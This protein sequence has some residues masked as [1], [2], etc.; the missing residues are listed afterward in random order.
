ME[1]ALLDADVAG[2]VQRE[3]NGRLDD[4]LIARLWACIADLDRIVPL[5]DSAY[6]AVYFA[7]LRTM[8]VLAATRHTP[9]AT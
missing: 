3:L 8:A 5:I 7:K 4:G 6:C 2:L 1:L 9:T